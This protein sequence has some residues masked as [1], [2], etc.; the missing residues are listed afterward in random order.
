MPAWKI[1]HDNANNAIQF[2]EEHHTQN[3]LITGKVVNTIKEL[4]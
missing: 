2:F 4:I 3:R 1:D